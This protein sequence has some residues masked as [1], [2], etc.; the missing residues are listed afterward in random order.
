MAFAAESEQYAAKRSPHCLCEWDRNKERR[1][2]T[3]SVRVGIPLAQVI[4]DTW[5]QSGFG[6]AEQESPHI[7]MR[8]SLHQ[9]HRGGE[10][11]P[12]NGD[13]RK[14]TACAHANEDEIAW[15][16]KQCV[17]EEEDSGAEPKC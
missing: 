16:F 7:K 9:H 5:K 4:D 14:P 15:H 17:A 13:P 10:Q 6:D 3:G 11:S 12:A 2:C 8:Q 1:D